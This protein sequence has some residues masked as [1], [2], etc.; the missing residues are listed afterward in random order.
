MD[1]NFEIQIYQHW[2]FVAWGKTVEYNQNVNTQSQKQ[3][4]NQNLPVFIAVNIEDTRWTC[5]TVPS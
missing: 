4:H 1:Q 3:K 2:L 5:K